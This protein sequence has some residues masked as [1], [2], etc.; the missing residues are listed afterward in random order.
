MLWRHNLEESKR[1]ESHRLSAQTPS[2]CTCRIKCEFPGNYGFQNILS[3]HLNSGSHGTASELMSIWS[4]AA[5]GRPSVLNRINS[6]L[7]DNLQPW[8]CALVVS[9]VVVV[10]DKVIQASWVVNL[11]DILNQSSNPWSCLTRKEK[12]W[13]SLQLTRMLTGSGGG[14]VVSS[15]AW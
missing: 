12:T 3:A 13:E 1:L 4:W 8:I 7:T 2:E 6:L 15:S 11:K 5:K 14:S 9:D 10:K